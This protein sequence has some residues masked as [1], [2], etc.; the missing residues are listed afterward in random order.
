MRNLAEKLVNFA[1]KLSFVFKE[2]I[3]HTNWNL[4]KKAKSSWRYMKHILKFVLNVG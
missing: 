4:L 1:E 2:D 3:F